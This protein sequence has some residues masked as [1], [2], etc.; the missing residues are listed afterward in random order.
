MPLLGIHSLH[1]V[2]NRFKVTGDS[3][4]K[5]IELLQSIIEQTKK[6]PQAHA[7]ERDL[8]DLAVWALD[9][10]KPFIKEGRIKKR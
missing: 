5:D 9:L 8:V 2:V 4:I 7:I 3:P 6:Q 1:L 10:Q